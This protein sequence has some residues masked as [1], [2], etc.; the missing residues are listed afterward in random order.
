MWAS[1]MLWLY[2]KPF[3]FIFFT[4]SVVWSCQVYVTLWV[5]I[6]MHVCF[7][8]LKVK[9]KEICI[10]ETM[11]ITLVVV[12]QSVS[13]TLQNNAFS[14]YVIL[15]IG[16]NLFVLHWFWTN[17]YSIAKSLKLLS[18]LVTN[19]PVFVPIVLV[20]KDIMSNI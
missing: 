19:Q 17:S 14:S 12:F 18:S 7:S 3:H 11:S 5:Q 2:F 16:L 10:Q 4:C 6:S 8:I 15:F 13:C 9:V 20:V 1:H